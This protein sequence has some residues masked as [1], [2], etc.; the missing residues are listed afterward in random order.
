MRDAAF[1][2]IGFSGIA[3]SSGSLWQLLIDRVIIDRAIRRVEN[4]F[5]VKIF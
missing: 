2:V 4:L 1:V 5:I 3:S